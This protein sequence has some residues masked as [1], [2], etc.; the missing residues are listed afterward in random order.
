M[1]KYVLKVRRLEKFQTSSAWYKLKIA[2]KRSQGIQNIKELKCFR[3]ARLAFDEI[4]LNAL[5]SKLVVRKRQVFLFLQRG[6]Q[7]KAITEGDLVSD[8]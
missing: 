5:R 8:F 1:L 6:I 4:K 7:Q 2:V 3:L